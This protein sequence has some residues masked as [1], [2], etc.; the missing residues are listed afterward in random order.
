[1]FDWYVYMVR[2]VDNSLYAGIAKDVQRRLQ[3][4]NADNRLGAKYTRGRRPVALV[5][6]QGFENRSEACKFEMKLKAM[7]K[8]EKENIICRDNGLKN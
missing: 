3:E 1:M 2:C 7:K 6:Q 8:S 5:Y 4:H